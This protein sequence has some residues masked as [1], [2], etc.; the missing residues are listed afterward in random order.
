LFA[1]FYYP[2]L[3]KLYAGTIKLVKSTH[4]LDVHKKQNLIE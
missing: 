4:S 3:E 1:L 2:V